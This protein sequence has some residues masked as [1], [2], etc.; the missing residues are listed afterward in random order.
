MV[1]VVFSIPL[2]DASSASKLIVTLEG[3]P[4]PVAQVN[5]QSVMLTASLESLA[6]PEAIYPSVP[7]SLQENVAAFPLISV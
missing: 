2:A 3:V 5:E 6:V 7:I 4:D 1:T